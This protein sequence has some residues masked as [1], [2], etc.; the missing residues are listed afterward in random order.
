MSKT[1]KVSDIKALFQKVVDWLPQALDETAEI[2]AALL[3]LVVFIAL[4]WWSW[5]PV[6]CTAYLYTLWRWDADF[7]QVEAIRSGLFGYFTLAATILDEVD[8]WS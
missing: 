5:V 6:G 7:D 8:E 4:P 3:A 2:L 1:P